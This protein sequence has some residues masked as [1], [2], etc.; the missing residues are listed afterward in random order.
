MATGAMKRLSR[1]PRLEGSHTPHN[2][3]PEE[4]KCSSG[5]LWLGVED[6]L[7]TL[8]QALVDVSALISL[9]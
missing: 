6:A 2:K 9:I 5:F 8:S 1:C 3:K 4:R 7:R